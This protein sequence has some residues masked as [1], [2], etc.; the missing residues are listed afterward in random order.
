MTFTA[1]VPGTV[2]GKDATLTLLAQGVE[3]V[4][5]LTADWALVAGESETK[6][7]LMGP[8]AQEPPLF[9]STEGPPAQDGAIERVVEPALVAALI[10][11]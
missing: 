11:A 6:A 4:T 8:H 5:G 1:P 10:G 3:T 2:I 7:W 9:E